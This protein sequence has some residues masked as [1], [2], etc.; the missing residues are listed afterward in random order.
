MR[1]ALVPMLREGRV[2]RG[3][4]AQIRAP[5]VVDMI[6]AAGFDFA[7]IDCEHGAFGIETAETLIRACDAAGLAPAVRVSRL[8][9]IEIMKALDAGAG[10][11]VVPNVETPEQAAEAVAATRFAPEGLRGACPCCRSGGHSIR[12][13]ETYRAR[14]HAETGAIP[15]V[16]TAA[17][18][19]AFA[20]IVAVPGLAAVMLGPF[21]LSVS[22]GLGGN[23]R[24]AAVQAELIRMAGLAQAAGVPVILPVFAP[25]PAE[26]RALI[27]EWQGR[28]VRTFAIGADKII[29]SDALAHWATA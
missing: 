29:L 3:T 20:R 28:G 15:L 21:D 2:L 17:G 5:E 16:E 9:R 1:R 11:V 6:G 24:D 14:Q 23:W 13:W 27:A 4:W 7:V 19:A 18:A 22:M 10:T 12:D 8:D 26:N 25:T